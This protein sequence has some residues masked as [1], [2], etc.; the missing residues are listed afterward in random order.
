MNGAVQS[1][2]NNDT[3][4][5][6]D[7]DVVHWHANVVRIIQH[8]YSDIT[9]G[10]GQEQTKHEQQTFVRI[11]SPQELFVVSTGTAINLKSDYLSKIIWLWLLLAPAK[12]R[13]SQ[14][15]PCLHETHLPE[16]N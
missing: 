15:M 14:I 13:M 8:G 2:G 9:S 10:P 3:N 12:Q 7:N 6:K 5:W 16:V 4:D 11:K 1:S